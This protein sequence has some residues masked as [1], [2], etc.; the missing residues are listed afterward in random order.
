MERTCKEISGLGNHRNHMT[1]WMATTSPWK[2]GHRPSS[3][4]ITWVK[5]IFLSVS[6][7]GQFLGFSILFFFLNFLTAMW[8]AA[9]PV[10]LAAQL[11]LTRRLFC[12]NLLCI[13]PEA[14]CSWDD[15]CCPHRHKKFGIFPFSAF[16]CCQIFC[17]GFGLDYVLVFTCRPFTC[18]PFV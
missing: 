15:I 5:H 17:V 9:M 14:G 7:P 18:F 16:V 1:W 11:L 8:P 2:T 6:D 10:F 4:N 12:L 3:S 13:G